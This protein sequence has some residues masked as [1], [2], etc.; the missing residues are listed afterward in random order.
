M[1]NVTTCV[2]AQHDHIKSLEL[3][4]LLH[5]A[6]RTIEMKTEMKCFLRMNMNVNHSHCGCEVV[7]VNHRRIW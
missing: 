2:S 4:L 3:E 5:E 7:I 6:W 1:L